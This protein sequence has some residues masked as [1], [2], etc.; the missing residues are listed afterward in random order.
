MQCAIQL[1]RAAT[2]RM[3]CLNVIHEV[4]IFAARVLALER[5]F[6]FESYLP[7]LPVPA[8]IADIGVSGGLF[9]RNR[10]G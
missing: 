10:E 7:Y 2:G 5:K 6:C 1:F 3:Q 9:V 4:T 8:D